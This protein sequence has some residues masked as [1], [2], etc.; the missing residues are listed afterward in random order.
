MQAIPGPWARAQRCGAK[1]APAWPP[2]P[3]ASGSGPR[4][5]R[6]TAAHP[7]PGAP[8]GGQAYLADRARRG[9]GADQAAG[10]LSATFRRQQLAAWG[11]L[12]GPLTKRLLAILVGNRPG[13][14]RYPPG[15]PLGAGT[16]GARAGARQGGR[17]AGLGPPQVQEATSRRKERQALWSGG[18]A[19]L[20][21]QA[22]P[23]TPGSLGLKAQ[24]EG[25]ASWHAAPGSPAGP[26]GPKGSHR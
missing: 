4:T 5:D 25:L 21:W 1:R 12:P 26:Y 15:A 23:G 10:A 6:A 7:G 11:A 19:R 16:Q 9:P 22:A 13:S 18:P 8:A 24:A 3:A 2:C 20:G 14:Y 17:H